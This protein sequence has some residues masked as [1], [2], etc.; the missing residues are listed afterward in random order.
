MIPG[1]S[2][3]PSLKLPCENSLQQKFK[4][5]NWN[6]YP[7]KSATKPEGPQL[8]EMTASSEET[9]SEETCS[10]DIPMQWTGC[11]RQ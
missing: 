10:Q 1:S 6:H 3:P 5:Q 2:I 8:H 9:S 7:S 11:Q 4:S